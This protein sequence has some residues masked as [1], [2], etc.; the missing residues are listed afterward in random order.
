MDWVPFAISPQFSIGFI[1]APL[2]SLFL[3][4][5]ILQGNMKRFSL[6]AGFPENFLFSNSEAGNLQEVT[7]K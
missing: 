6:A 7:N 4:L 1:L 5:E 3:Q 2:N